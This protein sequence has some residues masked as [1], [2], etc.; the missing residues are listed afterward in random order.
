MIDRVQLSK[1]LAE[2]IHN[3]PVTLI[4]G[5]RQCGKTTI[6]REIYRKMGG[7]YFDLED[8]ECPLQPEI[9]KT[10]LKEIRGLIVIDEIQRQANLFPII[11]VLADRPD[12]DAKFLILGSAS[13]E[14]IKHASE[15]LAGRISYI[16]MSGFNIDEA[17]VDSYQ[18]LWSR[19]GFPNSFLATDEIFSIDWR[20]NFIQTFLERDISQLG[21]RVPAVTLRRFW[22][23]VAHYHGQIWNA[24]DFAK[25]LGVKEDTARHYLDILSE[26]FVIR[27]LAPYFENV[28]KRVIKSPKIYVRDSGLLHALLDLRSFSEI[29]SYPRF[30]F[31]WEGF[32]IEQILNLTLSE[33]EAYFYKT[34]AGAELDLLITRGNRRIGFEIKYLDHPTPT[35]ST[36]IV[37]NDLNLSQLYIIYPG[38]LSYSIMDRVQVASIKSLKSI[39]GKEDLLSR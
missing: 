13:L 14:L 34:H 16:I 15:S 5:P 27:Q 4:T 12:A 38:E 10:V 29:Y 18:N 31:S 37:T 2:S 35:R 9:A 3:Y 36:H 6:A 21:I 25:S 39:L 7:T 8:P 33:R 20:K 17:G 22:N 23:M 30:G 11:R 28:G 1:R 24:A 26:T 19:G 32:V